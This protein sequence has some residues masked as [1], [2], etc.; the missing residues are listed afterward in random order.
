MLS[1]VDSCP[2]WRV[3]G[4]GEPA[5]HLVREL[6]LEPQTTRRIE[7]LLELRRDVPETGRRPE[8]ICVGPFEILQR[9]LRHILGLERVVVPTLIALYSLLRRQLMYLMKPYLR[10]GR[11]PGMALVAPL[12]I[13]LYYYQ[14]R[15][16]GYSPGRIGAGIRS[17]VPRPR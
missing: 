16:Q 5:D 7:E 4:A 6:A 12:E 3:L 1:S 15:V 2:P 9:S 8:D 14:R 11:I 10:P 17:L 13:D